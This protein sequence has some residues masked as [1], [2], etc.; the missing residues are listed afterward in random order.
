MVFDIQP[1]TVM[2]AS[3]ST[4]EPPMAARGDMR[5]TSRQSVTDEATVVR[6]R[7]ESRKRA[8][9][10]DDEEVALGQRIED[11]E[12]HFNPSSRQQAAGDESVMIELEPMSP[13]CVIH[14]EEEDEDDVA[15]DA[16]P[17][18]V[19][20]GTSDS[21]SPSCSSRHEAGS[22]FE[23][24]QR[25]DEAFRPMQPVQELR[26][27][28]SFEGLEAVNVNSNDVARGGHSD[29]S[30]EPHAHLEESLRTVHPNAR[31]YHDGAVISALKAIFQTAVRYQ[32]GKAYTLSIPDI[33]KLCKALGFFASNDDQTQFVFT[34]DV[35]NVACQVAKRLQ[36]EIKG[37]TF[38]PETQRFDENG[39]CSIVVSVAQVKQLHYLL[40]PD[41]IAAACPKVDDLF[42]HRPNAI[43]TTL[44]SPALAMEVAKGRAEIL[45]WLRS[46]H[47][48]EHDG[49]SLQMVV[50]LLT[51]QWPV[52]ASDVRQ[53][54]A[55]NFAIV[56]M[57]VPEDEDDAPLPEGPHQLSVLEL[58]EILLRIDDGL[59]R[60]KDGKRIA[61]PV[62][63]VAILFSEDSS[64]GASTYSSTLGSATTR[65][66]TNSSTHHSSLHDT[67]TETNQ[68]N[69]PTNT[70]AATET[71]RLTTSSASDSF[72][73][74]VER[75]SFGG[76]GSSAGRKSA[77][78]NHVLQPLGQRSASAINVSAPSAPSRKSLTL[79]HHVPMPLEGHSWSNCRKIVY[80]LSSTRRGNLILQHL[81]EEV[82]RLESSRFSSAAAMR[83]AKS[84]DA[85][86]GLKTGSGVSITCTMDSLFKIAKKSFPLALI[87][88]KTI[89]QLAEP[90]ITSVAPSA[91][92]RSPST[93]SMSGFGRPGTPTR[94]RSGSTMS[95]V[96]SSVSLSS[97]VDLLSAFTACSIHVY[98]RRSNATQSSTRSSTGAQLLEFELMSAAVVTDL[99]KATAVGQ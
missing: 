11:N 24:D 48:V 8:R 76:G 12:T 90:Y 31:Q 30:H 54:C 34:D 73:M 27:D 36:G 57:P 82:D 62:A 74:A 3:M 80:N 93:S 66:N 2:A 6:D 53:L 40:V 19:A 58:M 15:V 4:Q 16:S 69:L 5:S 92:S 22:V 29:E 70:T 50:E 65:Y 85:E 10:D 18:V 28:I 20:E 56:T 79:P 23:E 91:P 43:Y 42:S 37:F 51:K 35:F 52:S 17:I 87:S 55:T 68:S 64:D 44:F 9:D 61:S 45:A 21:R 96:T 26:E 38:D 72:V 41:T 46:Q 25:H 88:L 99:E 86:T 13:E 63:M 98:N 77:S 81:R 7:S 14:A 95:V 97:A 71:S 84:T 59:S 83:K 94:N 39:F 47:R 32:P 89:Q 1:K 49:H 67:T 78:G 33:C 75:M 60:A